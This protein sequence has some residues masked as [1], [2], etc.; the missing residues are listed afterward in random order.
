M[1]RAAFKMYLKQ[2]CKEEYRK[3]HRELWPEV[4]DLLREAGIRDYSIFLDERTHV[5]YAVQSL[6]G[7][8]GSQE[9]GQHPVIRKWWNYMADI[10]EV[11]PDKS[12]VSEPL[13][14]IFYLP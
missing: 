4:A 7:D 5:L 14:E 9:L 8:A 1:K 10:M 3:R 11:N 13:E 2:G 12:P 6:E